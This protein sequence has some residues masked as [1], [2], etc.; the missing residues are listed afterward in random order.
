MPLNQQTMLYN[1]RCSQ[2]PGEPL[3]RHALGNGVMVKCSPM[4]LGDWGLIPS[5][6]IPNT[7]KILLDT[8]MF[9]T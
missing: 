2:T 8:S 4:A 6:V 3:K 9:K 1:I 7:K 5:R